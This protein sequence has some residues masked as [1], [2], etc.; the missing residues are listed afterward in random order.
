[1]AKRVKRKVRKNV[2]RAIVHIRATFNNTLI[3]ITDLDGNTVCSSSTGCVGFKGSRKSTPFAAQRAAQRCAS[4][5][6]R[7][8]V[9]EVEIRVKGPGSGRESA[10]SALQQAGLRIASIEDVTPLPH[11]GCRPPKRRRV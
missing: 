6:M 8:G 9:R 11:N 1:M 4:T 10:I 3:T 7:N 2:V 5:A